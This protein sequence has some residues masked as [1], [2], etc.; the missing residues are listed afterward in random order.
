MPVQSTS[1]HL[2][3]PCCDPEIEASA[4]GHNPKAKAEQEKLRE[5]LKTT[6]AEMTYAKLSE[7]DS[8][9]LEN[10]EKV[11]EKVPNYIFVG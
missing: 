11:L 6:L 7:R 5:E 9:M 10:T 1:T 2:H 4:T 3:C 8:A